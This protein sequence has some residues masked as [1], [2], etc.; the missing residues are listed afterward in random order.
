[1]V[2][3]GYQ[4]VKNEDPKHVPFVERETTSQRRNVERRGG[5]SHFSPFEQCLRANIENGG[6]S[7]VAEL[8]R[9]S[10]DFEYV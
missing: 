9:V 4:R 6:R 8:K 1:M 2:C 5:Q 10:N 3:R 7:R